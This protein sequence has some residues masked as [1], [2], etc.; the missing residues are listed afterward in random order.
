MD[1]PSLADKQHL[2]GPD[3][4]G[5]PA[6][7]PPLRHCPR[8]STAPMQPIWSKTGAPYTPRTVAAA[9]GASSLLWKLKKCPWLLPLRSQKERCGRG[10]GPPLDL[11]WPYLR[12]STFLS[13]S[14]LSKPLSTWQAECSTTH[15]L[16][17]KLTVN[18]LLHQRLILGTQDWNIWSIV[19]IL[20][21]RVSPV[22]GQCWRRL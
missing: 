8:L 16:T 11:H 3:R 1:S 17:P 10:T 14:L 6:C 19:L 13:P 20:C 2:G 15:W 12:L 22:P 7:L 5:E 9:G 18:A 21:P 4:D